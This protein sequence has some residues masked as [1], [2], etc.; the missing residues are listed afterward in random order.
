MESGSHAVAAVMSGS[1]S[2]FYGCL[3]DDGAAAVLVILKIAG[4]SSSEWRS[5]FLYLWVIKY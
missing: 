1:G 3:S 4:R 5:F 2:R